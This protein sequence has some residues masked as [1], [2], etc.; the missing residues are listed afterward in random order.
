[1]TLETAKLM[2]EVLQCAMLRLDIYSERNI[3]IVGR[4]GKDVNFSLVVSGCGAPVVLY[5]KDDCITV[6]GVLIKYKL[7]KPLLGG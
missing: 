7:S 1:M 6:L 3:T 4:E 5:R 2:F